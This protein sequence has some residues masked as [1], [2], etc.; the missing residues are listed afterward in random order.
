MTQE[1]QAA[2][3]KSFYFRSTELTVMAGFLFRKNECTLS[4]SKVKITSSDQFPQNKL[5]MT[6]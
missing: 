1:N 2:D 6:L 5:K 3:D 4:A